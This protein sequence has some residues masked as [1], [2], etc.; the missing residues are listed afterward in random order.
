MAACGVGVCAV[1]GLLLAVGVGVQGMPTPVSTHRRCPPH[2]RPFPEQAVGRPS[3]TPPHPNLM[4]TVRKDERGVAGG[5]R[6]VPAYV[7]DDV[8]VEDPT[9]FLTSISNTTTTTATTTATTTTLCYSYT[10]LIIPTATYNLLGSGDGRLVEWRHVFRRTGDGLVGDVVVVAVV[11]GASPPNGDDMYT[12]SLDKVA[13][14]EMKV[15][16]NR[17]GW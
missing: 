6:L 7:E 9:P 16:V 2:P 3:L 11:T 12:T 14:R 17:T 10:D 8:C 13:V 15:V 5:V 1:A 4:V